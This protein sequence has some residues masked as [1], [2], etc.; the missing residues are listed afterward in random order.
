[1]GILA[2]GRLQ[3]IRKGQLL[4]GEGEWPFLLDRW[5][6]LLWFRTVRLEPNKCKVDFPSRLGRGFPAFLLH[7][8]R[9]SSL[10]S[11]SRCRSSTVLVVLTVALC[12]VF[13]TIFHQRFA[14]RRKAGTYKR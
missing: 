11:L 14:R 6:C 7:P 5:S 13:T 8:T 4:L 3:G 12:A 10:P 2:K 1:M 9:L